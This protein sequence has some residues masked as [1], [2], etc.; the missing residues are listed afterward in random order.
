MPTHVH[1]GTVYAHSLHVSYNM[2]WTVQTHGAYTYVIINSSSHIIKLS[3]E[4][5]KSMLT[6]YNSTRRKLSSYTCHKVIY[7]ILITRDGLR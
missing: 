1:S 4:V 7:T 5:Y 2:A 6:M 3:I